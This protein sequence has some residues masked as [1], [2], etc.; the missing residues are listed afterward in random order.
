MWNLYIFECWKKFERIIT[1]HPLLLRSTWEIPW[2]S[3]PTH[4]KPHIDRCDR[5]ASNQPRSTNQ[6]SSSVLLLGSYLLSWCVA[7]IPFISIVLPF[8]TTLPSSRSAI[9]YHASPRD[10]A[11]PHSMSSTGFHSSEKYERRRR[12][13]NTY[14]D[15]D[16]K[17]HKTLIDSRSSTPCSPATAY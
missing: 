10:P 15:D 7:R 14:S 12:C 16:S 11:S 9:Y 8:G 4:Q 3:F 5:P 2:Q 17:T 13:R 6:Y 1:R